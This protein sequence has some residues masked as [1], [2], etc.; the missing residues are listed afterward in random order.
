MNLHG[1][2]TLRSILKRHCESF[3]KTYGNL[4]LKKTDSF[5]MTF[6]K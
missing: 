5:V 6:Q 3:V 2:F 1:K 4:L